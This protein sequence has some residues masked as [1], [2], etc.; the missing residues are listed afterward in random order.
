MPE[1]LTICG[2]VAAPGETKE[3][4]VSIARLPTYTPIELPVNVFRSENDGPVL[5]FT[6]TMHGDEINGVEIIRRMMAEKLIVPLRGTVIAIPLVNLYGFIQR[7]RDLPDGKDINR[8]FP[9]SKNGSLASLV[10][11]TLTDRILP[12]VDYGIDYHTG[13]AERANYPQIR[14]S[15]DV[16]NNKKLAAA[17]GAPV[18][19]NSKLIRHSFREAAHKQGKTILVFETGEA[20]RFD[21][22]GIQEGIN[23][24]L[25][26]MNYLDMRNDEVLPRNTDIY[27]KKSW[28]RAPRSG[29]F[30]SEVELGSS[31]ARNQILGHISDPFGHEWNRIKS[32]H[33]GRVI[34]LNNAPVVNKGD[35]L[36]HIAYN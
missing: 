14:C 28:Q 25:R 19:V 30:H 20:R 6:G 22:V 12:H 13:G 17:F 24:A 35:A 7:Q 5:L 21:P 16:E 11:H 33:T 3:I 15:F 4:R 29:L 18:M 8:S 10:A 2:H 32:R 36:I 1:M 31:I 27:Q 26:L 34:G 23:G 9:G